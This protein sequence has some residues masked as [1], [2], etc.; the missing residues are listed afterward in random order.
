MR[1]LSLLLHRINAI[2]VHLFVSVEP[3]TWG[4]LRA[5]SKLWTWTDLSYIVN[6]FESYLTHGFIWRNTLFR[7]RLV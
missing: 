1:L 5:W 7:D 3:R 2:R 6:Y 4:Q